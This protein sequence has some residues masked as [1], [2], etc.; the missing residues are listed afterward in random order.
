MIYAIFSFMSAMFVW[1]MVPETKGRS[2]E[3]MA[4]L[5]KKGAPA[6]EEEAIA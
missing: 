2:L 6:K 3:E 1:K 4:T 5:W